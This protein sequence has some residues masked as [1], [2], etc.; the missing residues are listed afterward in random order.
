MKSLIQK[1][2][3]R[4]TLG[5]WTILFTACR[6]DRQQNKADYYIVCSGDYN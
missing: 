1:L 4:G 5:A 2:R 3:W 6:S